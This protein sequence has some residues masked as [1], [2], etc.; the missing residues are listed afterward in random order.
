MKQLSDSEVL[1]E[2]Q[3]ILFM[4]AAGEPLNANK[5][6][7]LYT[8]STGH[9][10]LDP[11]EDRIFAVSRETVEKEFTIFIQQPFVDEEA[12]E[13]AKSNLP[14]I[15]REFITQRYMGETFVSA[16][17]CLIC[18]VAIV[19]FLPFLLGITAGLI[20]LG[21]GLAIILLG[22]AYQAVLRHFDKGLFSRERQRLYRLRIEAC[23][24]AEKLIDEYLFKTQNPR[25][26]SGPPTLIVYKGGKKVN[27]VQ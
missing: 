24:L 21:I 12:L 2:S 17:I 6:L 22:L 3:G 14:S 23:N 1:S 11:N 16:I 9:A 20:V 10:Y 25:N 18:C 7:G 8:N 15:R 4:F 19:A 13:A 26:N 27:K 5:A